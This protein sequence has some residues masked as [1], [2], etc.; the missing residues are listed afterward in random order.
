[1]QKL[2]KEAKQFRRFVAGLE[3]L[4]QKTGVVIQSIGGVYISDNLDDVEGLTYT[5]DHTSGDLQPIWR[6]E[7]D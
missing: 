2:T 6:D 5:K 3:K 1:M 7:N 4:S